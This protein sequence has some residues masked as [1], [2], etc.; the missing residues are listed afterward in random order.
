MRKYII[1][2]LIT[3]GMLM[4][5][6]V[7]AQLSTMKS[8]YFQN[9]YLVNPSMAGYTGKTSAFVN[10]CNQWNKLVGAPVLMSISASTPITEKA[11]LGVNYISDKAGL[12]RRNQLMST[13]AYKVEINEE[14]SVRFGVSLSWSQ[15]RLDQGEATANGSNDPALGRYNEQQSYLDGNF[16]VAYIAKKF[17]AQFSYLN[18][19]QNRQSQFSTVDYSTFYS[20]ISY[21][22][23]LDQSEKITVKPLIAYRGIK[24]YDNLWDVAAEWGV[25]Q[26]KFYTM[27]HSNKSFSGGF[28]FDYQK[29]LLISGIFSTEPNGLQGITGGQFDLVLGYRF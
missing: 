17:E 21:K 26:M 19:N 20:S 23:G 4:A 7:K 14:S 24:G 3:S 8:Q 10:Y 16:G 29:S 6:G 12:I 18:L 22:F 27:Y 9:P 25:D 28:G 13:F 11:A 2:C 1:V 5:T 15:N